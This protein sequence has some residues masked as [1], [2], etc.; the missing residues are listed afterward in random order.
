MRV[1]TVRQ[2]W[3]WAIIHG[4]KDVENRSRNLAGGYR[5]PLAIHAGLSYDEGWSSRAMDDAQKASGARLVKTV[6]PW[7]Q[8]LGHI[9]GVVDLT[10]VHQDTL[11]T[12]CHRT[13]F[14]HS[15]P[16]YTHARQERGCSP[17]AEERTHHLVLA[18]PRPLTKPIPFKGG[19]GLRK[20]NPDTIQ[21]IEDAIAASS[22]GSLIERRI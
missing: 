17:W 22:S 11:A 21:R 10:D 3:A 9:I 13:V 16:D 20:L 8:H 19:L 12:P 1:L 2:P 15:H 7:R 5:G 6:E 4:G 18:N 14:D